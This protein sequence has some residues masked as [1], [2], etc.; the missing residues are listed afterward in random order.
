VIILVRQAFEQSYSTRQ[1]HLNDMEIIES[2]VWIGLGFVPTLVILEIGSRISRETP[3]SVPIRVTARA[4][5]E[6]S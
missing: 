6:A 5:S 2:I 3:S 4:K 1:Q